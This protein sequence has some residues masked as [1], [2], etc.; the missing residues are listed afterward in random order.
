IINNHKIK[1]DLTLM[2]G[3]S[4]NM[5]K[6][7]LV[8]EVKTAYYQ[9]QQ[10]VQQVQLFE[11]ALALVQENLRTTESLYRYNKQTIDV[12]YAAEAEVKKVERQIAE[13]IR[14]RQTAEA[15]FNFLLNRPYDEAIEISTVAEAPQAVASLD[16]ARSQA[17]QQREEMRQLDQLAEVAS[18]QVKLNKEEWLPNI[19]LVADYGVQGTNYRLDS[20]SDFFMGS[21]VMSWNIFN[22]PTQ[23]KV[24]QAQIEQQIIAQRNAEAKEQI[25]LEV[26]QAHYA[27]E[28]SRKSIDLSQQEL[29]YSQKAYQLVEKKFKQGQANLVELTNARTQ[30]TQAA[31][32]LIIARFDFQTKMA[33]YEHATASYIF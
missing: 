31:Q 9:Y 22:R 12:V 30:Q 18:K 4:V 21:L 32:K 29:K 16:Q 17:V 24:Q 1:K 19:N 23:A 10:T 2:E 8:K 14:A 15:Y 11:D 5:Y 7:T 20:D 6:R 33:E 25:G 13:A 3:I 28:S 26:V 27:L